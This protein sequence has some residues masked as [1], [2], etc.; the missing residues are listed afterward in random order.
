[1][2]G[3]DGAENASRRRRHQLVVVA[4]FLDERGALALGGGGAGLGELRAQL[5]AGHGS[6][7]ALLLGKQGVHRRPQAIVAPLEGLETHPQLAEASG[8]A[9]RQIGLRGR[10]ARGRLHLV[11]V[12]HVHDASLRQLLRRHA[13]EQRTSR[14]HHPEVRVVRREAMLLDKVQA[15]QLVGVDVQQHAGVGAAPAAHVHVVAVHAR[16][17]QHLLRTRG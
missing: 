4:L 1:M 5:H 6:E 3:C 15:E 12:K 2:R 16:A 11:E 8:A 10:R 7:L 9:P 14:L 13:P 17:D